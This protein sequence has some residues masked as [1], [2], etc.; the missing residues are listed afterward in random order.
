MLTT[1]DADPTLIRDLIDYF[2][3]FLIFLLSKNLESSFRVVVWCFC[4]GF[5]GEFKVSSFG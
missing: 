5:L 1:L 2:A 3:E 4:R